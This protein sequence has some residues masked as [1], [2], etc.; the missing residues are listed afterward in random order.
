MEIKDLPSGKVVYEITPEQLKEYSE[1]LIRAALEAKEAE[2]KPTEEYLTPDEMCKELKISKVSLW[3]WDKQGITCPLR[4]GNLKRY[5]RSD[6]EKI[7]N[8]I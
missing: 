4:I 3:N 2:K 1:N 7:M 6:L 8:E 5:R